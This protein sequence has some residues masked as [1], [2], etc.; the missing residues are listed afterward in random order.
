MN[1][2]FVEGEQWKMSHTFLV[3]ANSAEEAEKI[4]RLKLKQNPKKSPQR[5][6]GGHYIVGATFLVDDVS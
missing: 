2:Y 4:F 6:K 1:L 5:V 3:I